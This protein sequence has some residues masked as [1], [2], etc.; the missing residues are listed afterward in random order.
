MEI[1]VSGFDPSMS[2]W[3]IASGSLDLETGILSTPELLTVSP[4]DVT[5]KQVRQNS[6]DLHQAEQLASKALEI[7]R[8]S[9][10]VFVECPVGSQSARAMASYG[11]CVGILGAIRAEGIPLIEVTPIEVKLA[12]AGTKSATKNQMIQSAMSWY[13]EANFPYHNGKLSSTKAEHMADAIG[14]IHAGVKTPMFQ[15]LMRLFTGM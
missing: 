15:N 5:T 6:K 11:M 7:A 4:V 9:K 12:L 8:K 3:G 1:S 14:A 2:N 10:V 13:P